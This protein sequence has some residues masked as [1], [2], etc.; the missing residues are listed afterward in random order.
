MAWLESHQTLGQHPKLRRLALQL[1]IGRA[2]AVGHCMYLWWWCLDFAQDGRL[3]RYDVLDLELAAEWA[4]EPGVL[5]AALIEVGLLDRSEHGLA[6]HDWQDYAG[7][8]LERRRA[9]AERKR[10]SR[11][12]AGAD[13]PGRPGPAAASPSGPIPLDVRRT[14]AGRRAESVV[15]VQDRTV[16]NRTGDDAESVRARAPRPGPEAPPSQRAEDPVPE[17]FDRF[18]AAYPNRIEKKAAILVWRA[19][20]PSAELQE[21]MLAAI[22]RQ[23]R[24]RRWM[25]G[26]VKHPNRWLRDRNWEDETPPDPVSPPSRTRNGAVAEEQNAFLALLEARE[27]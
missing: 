15:T 1:G 11:P 7:R 6:V 10:A 3:D 2:Q 8:L 4:G 23:K 14:S 12:P 24:T 16:P 26:Y 25:E 20:R 13:G 17:G 18:W 19:L 22:E 21:E 9:D 5:I 27:G